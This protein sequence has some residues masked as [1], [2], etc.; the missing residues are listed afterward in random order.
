MCPISFLG[1][2]RA[3]WVQTEILGCRPGALPKKHIPILP[4]LCR[5]RSSCHW[6]GE[7]GQGSHPDLSRYSRNLSLHAPNQKKRS[8]QCINNVGVSAVI[9]QHG[10]DSSLSSNNEELKPA[11]YYER[12][13]IL[14]Q[15]Q[16]LE[17]T[18]RVSSHT[19]THGCIY[20][21]CLCQLIRKKKFQNEKWQQ[22]NFL[23]R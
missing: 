11:V 5:A 6:I 3:I 8:Q 18:S 2:D 20:P 17:N 16:G 13:K 21:H 14:R 1:F 10:M 9:P 7:R 12:L 15:R 23:T 22:C 19:D 4:E